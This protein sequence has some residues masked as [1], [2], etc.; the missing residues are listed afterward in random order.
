MRQLTEFLHNH[1]TALVRIWVANAL[2]VAEAD[3]FRLGAD[4]FHTVC[5]SLQLGQRQVIPAA[6]RD[7]INSPV[8]LPSHFLSQAVHSFKVTSLASLRLERTSSGHPVPPSIAL[9]CAPY[10][11]GSPSGLLSQLKLDLSMIRKKIG[12]LIACHQRS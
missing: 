2:P 5:F 1:P 7:M 8:T 11:A 12:L 10:C 3:Q 9:S 4:C 6:V